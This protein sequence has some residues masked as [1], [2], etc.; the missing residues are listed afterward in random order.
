ME[1][2]ILKYPHPVL[3]AKAEPVERI[4]EEVFQLAEAMKVVMMEHDGVGLAANQVGSTKRIFV[5]NTAPYEEQSDIIVAINPVIISREGECIEEEGCLS[6][7]GLRL[8]VERP[9]RVRVRFQTLFNE[10]LVLEAAEILARAVCHEVD[11]LDGI[12]FIDHAPAE[13]KH[14]VDKYMG[15]NP[16]PEGA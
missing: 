10:T 12:V 4:T 2:K 7:P 1:M 11:H 3:R 16:G 6:F 8:N 14:K 9:E 5:L 15:E 13:D